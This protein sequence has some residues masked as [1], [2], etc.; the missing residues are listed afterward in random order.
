MPVSKD[1]VVTTVMPVA[2]DP[3]ARRNSRDSIIVPVA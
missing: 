3:R 1:A 2:K